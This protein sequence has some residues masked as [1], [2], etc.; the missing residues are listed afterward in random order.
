MNTMFVICYL[1]LLALTFF[2]TFE[3]TLARTGTYIYFK[4]HKISIF[5]LYN[6]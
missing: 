6:I 2:D 5:E 3:N 4:L 1:I